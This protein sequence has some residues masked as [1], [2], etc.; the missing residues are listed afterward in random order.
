MPTYKLTLEYDGS[1]YAGWQRQPDR[2][3]IQAEVE[4]ALQRLTQTSI[5]VIGGG[6]TDAGVHALG[7]VASFR[8]DRGL[9][10]PLLVRGLNALLP[11]HIA[12][13][14]AELAGEDFHARYSARSKL[15]RYRILNR[16]ERSALEHGRAWHVWGDLDLHA[17]QEGATCLVGRHDCSSFQGSGSETDDALCHLMRLDVSRAGAL[18]TIEAEGDR[19]LKQMVRA[20]VGTLVEIGLR[21]R[22]AGSM[23]DVLEAR[24]RRAAGQTAPAHGLYLVRIDYP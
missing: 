16:R 23:K 19:F 18:V 15:Y 11:A 10:P 9:A 21:K 24:D 2:P 1:E 20:I 8:C 13:L 5:P 6:R 7:Q 12:V 22:P 14:G 17:M 4:S 3:S